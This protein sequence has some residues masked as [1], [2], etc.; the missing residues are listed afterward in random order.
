M[1]RE[2]YRSEQ[3]PELILGDLIEYEAGWIYSLVG[4]PEGGGGA[5]STL[6]AEKKAKVCA[7]IGFIAG[8]TIKLS[9]FPREWKLILIFPSCFSSFESLT[10]ST[11]PHPPSLAFSCIYLVDLC[12]Y[13]CVCVCSCHTWHGICWEGGVR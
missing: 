9:S 7:I 6:S 4:E 5:G 3:R 12:V 1:K 8:R 10:F 13:V 2:N 11:S